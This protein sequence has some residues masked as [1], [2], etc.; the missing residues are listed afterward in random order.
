[1]AEKVGVIPA[2]GLFEASFSVIVTVDVAIPLATTGLVPVMVEL[3]ATT[4]TGVK[5]TVPSLLEKGETSESVFVS[6]VLDFRL[7]V[8]TPVTPLMV[9]AP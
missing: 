5:I 6:A 3:A 9:Q 4:M 7:Q 1:M 2:T 8:D